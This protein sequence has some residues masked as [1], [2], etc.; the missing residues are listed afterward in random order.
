MTS[1]RVRL[2]NEVGFDWEHPEEDSGDDEEEDGEWNVMALELRG[3]KECNG[4]CFIPTDYFPNPKLGRWV[5]LQRQRYCRHR[6]VDGSLDTQGESSPPNS[7]DG[8]AEELASI[9]LYLTM[10]NFSF[11]KRSFDTLWNAR[12]EELRRYDEKHG[13]C[14]VVLD[15]ASPYY[16]VGEGATYVV[17]SCNVGWHTKSAK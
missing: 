3:F 11:A 12:F 13:D 14:D 5:H 16:P 9:G 6:I 4:H 17:S 8:R 15:Y 10:D 7:G 1:R 2:L